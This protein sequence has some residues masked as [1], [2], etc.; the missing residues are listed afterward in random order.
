MDMRKEINCFDGEFGFLSNFC[1]SK[2]EFEGIV[3][4]TVEHAF[5]AAKTLDLEE[6]KR[7]AKL[8]TAGKAKRAGRKVVLREDWEEIKVAIMFEL[9]LEK[10]SQP[11]FK[12]LL[13]ATGNARLVEGNTWN[14]TFWGVCNGIGKNNLGNILMEIR[15]LV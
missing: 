13:L 10:F 9:C 4:P 14:D 8:E 11:I 6:R 2:I 3:F 7:I 12:E 5:Q 15:R 1:P